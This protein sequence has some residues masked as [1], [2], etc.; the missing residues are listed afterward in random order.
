MTELPAF[1]KP[2]QIEGHVRLSKR[3]KQKLTL[4]LYY[5]QSGICACGCGW[6][7][8]LNPGQFDSVELDH[9][10]PQPMGHAKN[11][12][13]ENLRAVRHVCNSRKGS[14]RDY[15]GAREP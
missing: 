11:D 2:S 10:K 15:D 14:R 4:E 5:E 12:A 9:I 3:E 13:R 8:S 7:M 1:P 6:A